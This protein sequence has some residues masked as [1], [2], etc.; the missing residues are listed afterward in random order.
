MNVEIEYQLWK[1]RTDKGISSGQLAKLSGVGK[2]TINDIENGRHDPTVH[3]LCLL[4]ARAL[5]VAPED[6]YTYRFIP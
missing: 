2:T 4:A 1:I 6:L 3:T 5:D